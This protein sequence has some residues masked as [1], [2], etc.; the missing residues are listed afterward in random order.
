M[1]RNLVHK[2][3]YMSGSN[4]S[5]PIS[6]NP[7]LKFLTHGFISNME[8]VSVVNYPS[9]KKRCSKTRGQISVSLEPDRTKS[10]K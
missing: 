6:T 8:D 7:G 3:I 10:T 2:L 4:C 5:K 1:G 9:L